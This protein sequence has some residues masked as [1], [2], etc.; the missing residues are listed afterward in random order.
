M[1]LLDFSIES[2]KVA[3]PL[4]VGRN[5][6][7]GWLR[8]PPASPK[9]IILHPHGTCSASAGSFFAAYFLA[10][11][12]VQIFTFTVSFSSSEPTIKVIAA[13]AMGYQSPE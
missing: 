9:Q 7:D 1:D 6:P 13:T 5:E 3:Q 12:S 8:L 10:P 4:G 2:L 11:T